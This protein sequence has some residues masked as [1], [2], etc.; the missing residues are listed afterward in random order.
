MS[1][2]EKSV[3]LNKLAKEF[4][5]SIDRVLLFL[6]EKGVE[7]VKASSKVSHNLYMDLLGEFQ[8]DLKAKIAAN[9]ASKEREEKREKQREEEEKRLEKEESEKQERIKQKNK[10]TD[11]KAVDDS[12]LPLDNANNK[13]DINKT[14]TVIK[15][16]AKRLSGVKSTGETIDL[17]KLKSQ[18]TKKSVVKTVNIEDSQKKKRKRITN[19]I[20]PK[21]FVYVPKI[22]P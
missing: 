10:I 21:K 14:E 3:R 9:L 15:A 18:T 19:K 1:E 5:V 8:P 16:S 6:K 17:D 11:I 22:K 13:H 4:N 2:K 20:N 7:G 12:D